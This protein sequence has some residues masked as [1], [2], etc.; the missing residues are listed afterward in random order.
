MKVD[1]TGSF[2]MR[3]R[4]LEHRK[5]IE[6]PAQAEQRKQSPATDLGFR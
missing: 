5:A 1:Q 6:L 4:L 2:T 3:Y